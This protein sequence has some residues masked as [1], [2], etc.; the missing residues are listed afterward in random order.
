MLKTWDARHYARTGEARAYHLAAQ[1]QF[2]TAARSISATERIS[3]SSLKE[4]NRLEIIA[5]GGK[6]MMFSISPE[7]HKVLSAFLT[8]YPGPLASRRGYQCA[9]ARAAHAVGGK[10]CS[11][12]G[13]RRRAARDEYAHRYHE[14]VRAG[15]N[16]KSAADKAAGDAIEALGHSR[17]RGDHRAWYLD[18]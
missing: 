3:I 4:G 18:R 10:A 1:I 6:A 7:L 11:T 9:Y 8:Q 16:S 15:L 5:K 17:N 14:A 2:E 13:I 12:H